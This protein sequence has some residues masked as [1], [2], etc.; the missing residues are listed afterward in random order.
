MAVMNSIMVNQPAKQGIPPQD[1][2]EV[3]IAPPQAGTQE[4]IPSK[5]EAD[6]PH[7]SR[8]ND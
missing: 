4:Q 8:N 3:T 2:I 5:K 1:S 6:N 7:T